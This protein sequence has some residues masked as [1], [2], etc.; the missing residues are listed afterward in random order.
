MQINPYKNMEDGRLS[1]GAWYKIYNWHYL[2]SF[3][4]VLR[5]ELGTENRI[6]AD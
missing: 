6:L 4:P 2:R 5:T 1:A 3:V